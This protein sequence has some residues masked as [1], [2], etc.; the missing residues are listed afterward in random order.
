MGAAPWVVWGFS[1]LVERQLWWF[2]VS[3]QPHTPLW[4]L[5]L[6]G[7]CQQPAQAGTMLAWN[8]GLPSVRTDAG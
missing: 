8:E 4:M 2:G 5:L 7:G 6:L 1:S 3:T